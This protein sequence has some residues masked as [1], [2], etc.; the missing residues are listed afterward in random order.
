[1]KKTVEVELCIFPGC[2]RAVTAR[3]LCK[4]HYSCAAQLVRDNKTSWAELEN[5]GK[6]LP[7]F[8]R[9]PHKGYVQDYF[10]GKLHPTQFMEL[11]HDWETRRDEAHRKNGEPGNDRR[12]PAKAN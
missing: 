11:R 9:G 10:L 4:T 2:N 8:R 3:G 12:A 6:S 1:M 7:T 5:S